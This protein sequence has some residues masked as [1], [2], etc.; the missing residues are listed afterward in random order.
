MSD[1]FAELDSVLDGM[2]NNTSETE[3]DSATETT[4]DDTSAEQETETTEEATEETNESSDSETSDSS[5]SS[6]TEDSAQTKGAKAFAAMRSENAQLKTLVKRMAAS[7]GLGDVKD[8]ELDKA[9]ENKLIADQAKANNIPEALQRKF[10]EQDDIIRAIAEERQKEQVV[11]AYTA[12]QKECNLSNEQVYAFVQ[13]LQEKGY[14]M[15]KSL[16]HLVDLYRGLHFQELTQ[17]MVDA[18][19]QKALTRQQKSE[20]QSSTPSTKTGG[21]GD[22]EEKVDTV[23]GLDAL[24]KDV[25]I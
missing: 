23:A 3:Q 4:T 16:P 19:V 14:D 22:P 10:Q 11:N 25:K 18:A 9:I 12:L 20:K 2:D 7:L 13:E 6:T 17:N 1:E 15:Q 24:L 5:D 8:D 21:A